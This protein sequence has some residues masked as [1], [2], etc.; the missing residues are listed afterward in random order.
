[1][2]RCCP[3]ELSILVRANNRTRASVAGLLAIVD[4]VSARRAPPSSDQL[5]DLLILQLDEARAA[6]RCE[7]AIACP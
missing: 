5:T 7:R 1:M 3:D 6:V 4:A 2:S